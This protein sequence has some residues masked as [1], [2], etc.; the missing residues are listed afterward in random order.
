MIQSSVTRKK[1]AFSSAA[2]PGTWKT[3]FRNRNL[4]STITNNDQLLPFFRAS[5]MTKYVPKHYPKC[6][7]CHW[8]LPTIAH[9]SIAKNGRLQH[10][11][12]K[13]P[14]GGR[15]GEPAMARIDA[16]SGSEPNVKQELSFFLQISETHMSAKSLK[17][18]LTRTM[19]QCLAHRL[20]AT[21]AAS[22]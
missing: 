10:S 6:R 20:T 15:M 22:P 9:I 18:N 5:H 16:C 7:P 2:R 1:R 8:V 13:P 17:N 19:L 14:S 11:G 3:R 12:T 21:F 4:A